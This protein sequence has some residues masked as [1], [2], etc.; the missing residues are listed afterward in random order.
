M[1]SQ[2]KSVNGPA[3]SETLLTEPDNWHGKRLLK[4]SQITKGW[5]KEWMSSQ[6]GSYTTSWHRSNH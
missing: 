6:P 4:A 1:I 3:L 5:K 2:G